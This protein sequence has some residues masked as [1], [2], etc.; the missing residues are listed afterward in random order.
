MLLVLFFKTYVLD[1]KRELT[2]DTALLVCSTHKRHNISGVAHTQTTQRYWCIA[3]T[4]DTTLLMYCTHKRHNITDVLH[5]QTTT[6][7]V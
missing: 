5:T 3:H 6:L 4:N 1:A 2:N 7:L